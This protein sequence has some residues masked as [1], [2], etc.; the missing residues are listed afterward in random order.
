MKIEEILTDYE[1]KEIQKFLQNKPMAN[2]VKKVLLAEIYSAGTL[3]QDEI[4]DYRRNFVLSLVMD[5]QGRRYDQ[6]NSRLGERVRACIE[7]IAFLDGGFKKL[8]TFN[9]QE[10]EEKTEENPAR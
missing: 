6:D 3:N 8:E 9:I 1:K 2:A 4:Y 7:G 10:V 5:E